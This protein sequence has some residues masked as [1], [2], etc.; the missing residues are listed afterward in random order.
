MFDLKSLGL[1]LIDDIKSWKIE[2]CF[3][4]A[5]LY[6]KLKCGTFGEYGGSS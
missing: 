3:G 6:F 5:R 2:S 1:L 4:L